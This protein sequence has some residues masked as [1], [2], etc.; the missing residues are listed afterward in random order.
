MFTWIRF[1][2]RRWRRYAAVMALWT[3][4]GALA[5]QTM[6]LNFKDTDLESVIG[7]VA[8]QTGRNFVIDPRVKG[9]VTIVSGKPLNKKEIYEVFLSVLQVH[10]FA[11]VDSGEI[12]K[13]VPDVNAKQT[14]LPL[15]D[16]RFP[17]QGDEMVTRVIPVDHVSAAQLVPILRPL[18]PQQGHMVAYQ[19]SNVLIISDRAANIDRLT[20]II[21]R[22]D[23][24]SVED[25]IEVIPLQHASAAEVVRI[26]TA[27]E[28]K[29]RPSGQ[30]AARQDI[31]TLIAD[32]RTNTILVSGGKS[33]RLRLRAIVSHLDIPLEREGNIHVVYLRYANAKELVPVLTGIGE[34]VSKETQAKKGKTAPA[35]GAGFT[36]QAD[37]ATNALVITAPMEVFRSLQAVIRQL[38]VRRAQVLVEGVIADI[39]LKRAAELG[40]QWAANA[41]PD[42]EGPVGVTNFA[43]GTGSSIGEIG[44][45][46]AA[47]QVPAIP[48]G[49]TMGIGRF[50]SDGFSIAALIR[51]L[52][53]DGTSN[54][55]STPSLLTLDNEEAEIVVG[56]NV[57]FI[58]GSFTNVSGA[59]A[60]SN[61]FQTIKRENVG[62][63][64][65][66]KPTINEGSTIKLEVEQTVDSLA[67]SSGNA[68]DVITN[69]RSIRTTVMVD[70]GD[71]VVLGGLLTDDLRENVQKVPGLG[72]IPLLGSLFR[73]K[74]T[75]K[76]K[77]SLM[78]FLHPVIMRDPE[79]A[80]Q[81]TNAKYN[82]MR[83]QQLGLQERGVALLPGEAVPV[84]PSMKAL[85]ELP[86]PFDAQGPDPQ[87]ADP[88]VAP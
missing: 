54:V 18:V 27:L 52:R 38:D 47:N 26:L 80:A 20:R 45:A 17:G 65:K 72:D 3:L 40:V 75:T 21:A 8:E 57:P 16:R 82:F 67:A 30:Q 66:V 31:P 43:S 9:K 41:V 2:G 77:T 32:E 59:A 69:T 48:E 58:T 81:V 76:D 37:E 71:V 19:P 87:T 24:P 56:Q 50:V 6:T 14:G 73:Y 70:D 4:G 7:W 29:T 36:I 61:P 88:A 12:V 10:G 49:L 64:L 34:S 83:A 25:E 42:R 22:I 86:A 63:T 53:G 5:A 13:I 46:I 15:A 79:F 68:A 1:Q 44:G 55:L 11:A 85:T 35:R 74:T 39:S 62:V 84:M 28:Q 23:Q 60:P 51:A 33:K 78:V